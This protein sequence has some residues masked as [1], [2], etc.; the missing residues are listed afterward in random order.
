MDLGDHE[1]ILSDTAASAGA[2][3]RRIIEVLYN[4]GDFS[5]SSETAEKRRSAKDPWYLKYHD[6]L[7]TSDNVQQEI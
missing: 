6:R 5:A 7:V 1:S 3:V 4:V 2:S